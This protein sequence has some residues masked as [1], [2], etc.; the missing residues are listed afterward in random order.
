MLFGSVEFDLSLRVRSRYCALVE[1]QTDLR[2]RAC[3]SG[4][5]AR[6]YLSYFRSHIYLP[7]R[8]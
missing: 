4:A 7:R 8:G 3:S 6:H 1:H 2:D 5:F